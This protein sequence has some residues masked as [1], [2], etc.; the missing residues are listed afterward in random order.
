[1][2]NPAK[3]ILSRAAQRSLPISS[4]SNGNSHAIGTSFPGIDVIM[5]RA[6]VSARTRRWS[7]DQRRAVLDTTKRND[8]GTAAVCYIREE[9]TVQEALRLVT[10]APTAEERSKLL[11]EAV[12]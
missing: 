1:M 11:A 7:Y 10:T 8:D 6:G 3:E 4:A 12:V 5:F 9:I 2:K